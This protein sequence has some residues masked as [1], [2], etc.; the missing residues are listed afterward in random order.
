[1]SFVS[2]ISSL[3]VI[4]CNAN[5][6]L[7]KK[8]E[9]NMYLSNIVPDV[10]LVTETKLSADIEDHAFLWNSNYSVFRKDRNRDGG[11]VCIILKNSLIFECPSSNANVNAE[12]IF[13]DLFFRE[14]VFRVCVFYRPPSD[15]AAFDMIVN[16][17]TYLHDPNIPMFVVGD[18]NMPGFDWLTLS[19]ACARYN[20]FAFEMAALGMKQMIDQPTRF[21]P[22]NILDL[23]FTSHDRM[24]KNFKIVAPLGK[25]DHAMVSFNI[26]C[27]HKQPYTFWRRDF[28]N[29]DRESISY[30]FA[31]TDWNFF[32]WNAVL[33]HTCIFDNFYDAFMKF[34]RSVI[35]AYVPL[36]QQSDNSHFWPKSIIQMIERK[37]SLFKTWTRGFSI[38]DKYAY[39]AVCYDLNKC[40]INFLS[41][42]EK[43]LSN[44]NDSRNFYRYANTRMKTRFSFP[45]LHNNLGEKGITAVEKARLLNN[46][47]GSVYT[48]DDN[49]VPPVVDSGKFCE[50][51][52]DFSVVNVY[53]WLSKSKDTYVA[54]PDGISSCFCKIFAVELA[55]PL[56]ILYDF[57]YNCGVVC[58]DWRDANVTPLHKKG[59][60]SSVLNYRDISIVC[61][62]SKPL[63]QIINKQIIDFCLRENIICLEQHAYLAGRSTTTNLLIGLKDWVKGI[64]MGNFTDCIFLDIQ[65]AFNSV[66]HKKLIA[67]LH[68]YG[69]RG[70][71]LRWIKSFL[72]D[73]RQRVRV[74]N[75][76]S[77]FISVSS[78][79]P[80]GSVLGPTLFL[81]YINDLPLVVRHSKL[82][83]YAD[84][85]KVYLSMSNEVD[86]IML[87]DDLHRIEQWT[88]TW[89]M[90]LAVAKCFA[91]RFSN[92]VMDI[93]IDYTLGNAALPFLEKTKDLGIVLSR[94]LKF[95][96]HVDYVV[97][98]ALSRINLIS[99]SFVTNDADVL[100]KLYRTYVLPI[101]NYGSVV[102]NPKFSTDVAKIEKCQMLMMRRIFQNEEISSN[103]VQRLSL[104]KILSLEDQRSEADLIF[105][106]KL[107]QGH[108]V[109]DPT[110]FIEIFHHNYNTRGHEFKLV[111]PKFRLTQQKHFFVNRT[112]NLWNELDNNLVNARSLDAFKRGLRE[113]LL[114][115][116]EL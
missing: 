99:Y 104:L 83:M 12:G 86:H 2:D 49:L 44:K 47:F 10:F 22:P 103:Y 63:E 110:D 78:G 66:P 113:Y 60:K 41:K 109:L 80:Q 38:L 42:Y 24:L 94:N 75:S 9:L 16:D 43:K 101:L 46:F 1:V 50:L 23:V 96:E 11:G 108:T 107:L 3:L 18:F 31:N 67:K 6:L 33:D 20:D 73:R 71:L 98:K 106:F 39:D 8:N 7:S 116:H 19:S 37:D 54:G 102:W 57:S 51:L 92:R 81:L 59:D 100:L 34:V 64:D 35:D 26:S 53:K 87:L 56:S 77:S 68:A 48:V 52:P 105:L 111:K 40:Q 115:S 69:I 14:S 13:V 95:H 27:K 79:V 88:V 25:S 29:M 30:I 112:V 28:K 114:V 74:E 72:N 45:V 97:K 93:D 65:K 36:V 55:L 15:D 89:N 91:L 58:R 84:D 85:V 5:G 90:N 76:Y 4:L 32:F 17:M 70:K 82:L 61:N 62:F 21:S